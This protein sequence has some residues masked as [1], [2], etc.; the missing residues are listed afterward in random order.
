MFHDLR[1]THAAMLIHEGLHP[2]V[3]QERMGHESIRTT[4]DRY[5]H[6]FPGMDEAAADALDA[7]ARGA[8]VGLG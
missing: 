3:I 7:A 1:H 5:G 2:K 4:L 6:L 8:A